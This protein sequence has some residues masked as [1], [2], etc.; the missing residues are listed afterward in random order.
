[1]GRSIGWVLAA[2]AGA[3]QAISPAAAQTGQTAQGAYNVAQAAFD[4]SDW[5][6]AV[7]GFRQALTLMNPK[8]RSVGVV[9]A[10]LATA[11]WSLNQVADAGVEAKAAVAHFTAIGVTRGEDLSEAYLLLG[12]LERLNQEPLAATDAFRRASAAADGPHAD[13]QRLNARLGI[14][15]SAM[16]ADPTL[17]ASTLDEVLADAAHMTALGKPQQAGLYARRAR[18]ELNRGKAAAAVPFIEKA[19]TLVGRTSTRVTIPQVQIR[20]DAALVYARIGDQEKVRQYLTY[21][22]AG[23]LPD[24]GWL[25]HADSDLP[26]CGEDIRP[27]DVAVV[28]FAIDVDGRTL[29]ASPVYASRPGLVGAA[30]A[31][32]VMSWRWSPREVKKLNAFWRSSVRIELRC[33]TRPPAIELVDAFRDAAQDWLAAQGVEADLTDPGLKPPTDAAGTPAAR[34]LLETMIALRQAQDGKDKAAAGAALQASMIAAH[35]PPDAQAYVA[36]ELAQRAA[37]SDDSRGTLAKLTRALAGIEGRPGAARAAAWLRTEMALM[38]EH[39]GDLKAARV[40]LDAISTLPA[41]TL[42]P[43]DPIR[44]IALLHTSLID[45]HMGRAGEAD[46]RLTAAGITADQCSL[47]DVRPVPR[48]QQ[49]SSSAFPA[50]AMRWH[51]EGS[52]REAFDIDAS[53]RVSG[54]RTVIAYP[55]FVFGAATEKAIANF[56]YIPPTLGDKALGCAAKTVNVRYVLP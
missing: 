42:P 32:A 54:V 52:V 2:A 29:G 14:A 9:R 55:P 43:G 26:V 46:A 34:R 35:L 41:A 31:K 39:G 7:T 56:R 20:G 28:E 21:S 44:S 5:R 33:V 18:A 37:G 47:L 50:E 30:F 53:G 16:T 22:G 11:L 1:M 49:I 10:R 27:D 12:T 6:A 17:A 23:H 24:N 15:E 4:R 8:S 13:E 3:M 40:Q 45:K 38:L 36:Y 48:N 19:L 25:T 51:F